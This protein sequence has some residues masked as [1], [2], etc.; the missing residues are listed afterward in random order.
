MLCR[1]RIGVEWRSLV[2]KIPD[3]SHLQSDIK[4]PFLIKSVSKDENLVSVNVF[5]SEKRSCEEFVCFELT[6]I[7]TSVIF[8]EIELFLLDALGNTIVSILDEFWR[9]CAGDVLTVRCDSAIS[10]G[11]VM[12]TIEMLYLGR[13]G[14]S[15]ATST[16]V[17]CTDDEER[18]TFSTKVLKEDLKS[19]YSDGYLSDVKLKTKTATFPVHKSMLGARS[20][21]FKAMFSSDMRET[22]GDTVDIEDISDDTLKRMLGICIPLMWKACSGRMP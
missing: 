7:D 5:L 6:T 9:D 22:H 14:D 3:F 15:Q 19:L 18:L 2:W 8:T 20:S 16:D 11:I 1:S 21:V 4:K 12:E 13:C 17:D 10:T